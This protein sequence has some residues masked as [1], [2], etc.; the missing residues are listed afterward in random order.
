MESIMSE[1]TGQK[2]T[3]QFEMFDDDHFD[4]GNGEKKCSKCNILL[5]LSSFSKSDGANYLRAECRPCNNKLSKVRKALHLE[6]GKAPD[7]YTCPICLGSEE[8]VRGKGNTKNGSWVLDH[9]HE[10]ESFRG[11]LCHKCNRA[12]GGF[13]DDTDML[14]RAIQYLKG[15]NNE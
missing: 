2:L 12:L 8:G 7:N 3:E 11:W 1:T 4:L 6:Y 9:C 15:T 10:T 14:Y 5:P 13:D